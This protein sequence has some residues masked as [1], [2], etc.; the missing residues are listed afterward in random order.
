[1]VTLILLGLVQLI[2]LGLIEK[3]ALPELAGVIS[4][5]VFY[6]GAGYIV[7]RLWVFRGSDNLPPA[8]V[9]E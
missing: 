6:T 4:G 1:M 9:P 5:M 8:G 3:L 7:N 2:Q